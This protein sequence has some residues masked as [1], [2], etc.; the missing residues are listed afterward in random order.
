M[1]RLPYADAGAPALQP[2]VERIVAA[3]GS[4]LHLDQMLLHSPAVADGWL[5]GEGAG[6][7]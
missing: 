2:L 6:R 4:V 7:L 1:A 3:R 5:S